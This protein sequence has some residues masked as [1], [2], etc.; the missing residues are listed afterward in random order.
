MD[1]EA[2]V[3]CVVS[4]LLLSFVSASSSVALS[5]SLEAGPDK[6]ANSFSGTGGA[7]AEA[8]GA[9]T[10]LSTLAGTS[11]VAGAGSRPDVVSASLVSVAVV[12]EDGGASS[13]GR[14]VSWAEGDNVS[15]G[16]AVDASVWGASS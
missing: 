2:S 6:A 13:A 8:V 10:T 4:A 3:E 12:D 11:T 15:G 5:D 16:A 9:E 7:S 14:D 1:G